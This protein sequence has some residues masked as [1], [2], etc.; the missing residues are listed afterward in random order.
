MVRGLLD[1]VETIVLHA[2]FFDWL[3]N[4]EIRNMSS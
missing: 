4:A 3:D 2:P 1:F